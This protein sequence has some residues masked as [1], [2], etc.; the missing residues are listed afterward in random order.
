M[1][2]EPLLP[3]IMPINSAL[4]RQAEID[5]S[6]K[7]SLSSY[8]NE[9]RKFTT[10][11][12]QASQ[13]AVWL[14]YAANYLLH[15]AGVHWAMDPYALPA[16]L[17]HRPLPAYQEDLSALQLVA[18]THAHADHLDLNLVAALQ[19]SPITWI[20]PGFMQERI[21]KVADLSRM[22]VI[23]PEPGVPI[24]FDAL[25]LLP[26][27]GLHIRGD[28]GVPEIGYLAEFNGQR[29]LFPGDTR[30][31]EPTRLPR[32][33]RLDGIFAHL[34]LGKAGALQSPPPPAG[35]VLR[36]FCFAPTQALGDQPP[37]GGG[38]SSRGFLDRDPFSGCPEPHGVA[39][40]RNSGSDGEM[41]P[42]NQSRI[43][44]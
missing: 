43:G 26:F 18:F 27:D 28:Q 22:R 24:Q 41:L 44:N 20:I 30:V 15:T 1:R 14:T 9:W 10:D 38:E 42:E 6:I 37:G 29:W 40:A 12:R 33:G 19:D 11:W 25:T 23:L 39:G 13:D 2:S 31:Y 4:A 34:W 16:R 17:K 8:A 7:I 35:R 3:N 5:E 21:R 36:L 32:L